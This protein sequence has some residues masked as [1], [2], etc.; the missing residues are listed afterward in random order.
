MPLHQNSSCNQEQDEGRSL[1]DMKCTSCK[2]RAAIEITP[3]LIYLP[4]CLHIP[5]SLFPLIKIQKLPEIS[6]VFPDSLNSVRVSSFYGAKDA[7]VQASES[8]V[9]AVS[10]L[11]T[12]YVTCSEDSFLQHF[13]RIQEE[14]TASRKRLFNGKASALS[15]S[16]FVV[17]FT[18]KFQRQ[19]YFA[20]T[21]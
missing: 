2:A 11:R 13:N 10:D 16:L 8:W 4:I 20:C 19:L 7:Y 3:S 21:L 5:V 17:K 12:F 14:L 1:H 6:V 9:F 15:L 18:R